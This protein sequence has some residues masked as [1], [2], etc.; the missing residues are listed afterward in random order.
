VK[1]IVKRIIKKMF[2]SAFAFLKGMRLLYGRESY[3]VKTGLMHT[4]KT[5]IPSRPDGSPLPWMNYNVI[6]FLEER[7]ADD[8]DLFEYG[9]GFSTLFFCRLV[10]KVISVEY[11][12]D[13]LDTLLSEVPE[14]AKIIFREEDY[15]GEYCRAIKE[16]NQ[17]FDVI[18]IDGRDRVNCIKQ[19]HDSLSER[20]I[21]ILDDSQREEYQE[22]ISFLLSKG[23]KK[24]DFE[25][26]KPTGFTPDR[27]S[28]F[29][30]ENNCVGI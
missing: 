16:T 30:K 26:L 23:F 10:N 20:G 29:Y 28:I 25:G 14:N 19:S 22:G 13:L 6:S 17:L 24:I 2:P 1:E 9:S 8:L 21:I 15:D 7:L 18:V 4:Y 27:T 5:G 3:L 12:K 11:D